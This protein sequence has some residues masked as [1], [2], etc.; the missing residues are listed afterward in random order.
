[1][2]K[3]WIFFKLRMLQL[4]LDGT[5]V[6]FC[7]VLPALLLLCVG[8][9]LQVK[10]APKI[11]VFYTEAAPNASG[12]ALVEYLQHL[13][14]V[15]VQRYVDAGTPPRAALEGN[16][17]KHYLEIGASGYGVYSNSLAE[18]QIE[19]VALHS[20]LGDYSGSHSPS[21][22]TVQTVTSTK[23]TS[24]LVTLL[25][26][27][28]GM[29]LLIIGLP[30]FGAILI[31]EK[32]HGLYMNLKTIDVSPI[33]FLAGMFASRLLVS[34]SV[35]VVLFVL[36]VFVFGISTHVN[37]LLLGF[38]VTLGCLA[39]L[40]LGL[41]LATISPSLSAFNGIVNMVQLPLVVLGGVFF[42][43]SS[44]PSWLQAIASA[45]PLAQLNTA[46]R[47]VLFD[48]VGFADL[49][50]LYPQITALTVWCVLTLAVARVRFKW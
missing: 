22:F 8:Y 11:V 5:A 19:N 13:P 32:H 17:I 30:G 28:I 14:L 27:L 37:Y 23:T 39:F 31:T 9:S 18:N 50:Q 40:G 44:F 26:G 21:L 7:Y 42:S 25:P 1:M 34:Y 2:R 3:T 38:V 10:S 36:A 47:H 33:P 46:M 20:L 48:Y 41:M 6:F 43:V 24:Y 12:H 4:R 45:L 49:S 16:D 35:A 15:E 29:T